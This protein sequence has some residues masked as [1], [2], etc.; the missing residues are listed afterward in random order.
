MTGHQMTFSLTQREVVITNMATITVVNVLQ[1]LL[2]H[3]LMKLLWRGG[4]EVVLVGGE[5]E[6]RW[7]M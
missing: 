7:L 2:Y 4:A 3:H 6:L 1:L 5:V